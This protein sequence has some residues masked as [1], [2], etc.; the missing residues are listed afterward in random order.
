MASG[1]TRP[2]WC[3]QHLPISCRALP[4]QL[5]GRPRT[6]ARAATPRRRIVTVPARLARPQRRP[7]CTAV[8]LVWPEAG[9]HCSTTPCTQ[10]TTDR[11][12][13]T[14][15]RHGPTGKCT[16]QIRTAHIR[17]INQDG[18]VDL[19][20]IAGGQRFDLIPVITVGIAGGA[21]DGDQLGQALFPQ[22]LR[23]ARR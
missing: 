23:K 20:P 3:A 17:E 7:S 10:P 8:A 21:G 22:W 16:S 18:Q 19:Q 15:R 2:D 9:L 11:V 13:L 14:T 4:E 12:K 1:R 6:V 5:P